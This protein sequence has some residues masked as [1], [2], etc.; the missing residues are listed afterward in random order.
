VAVSVR[1]VG[2]QDYEL[3]VS[4]NGVGIPE[5]ADGKSSKS[6]GL[7]L[8]GALVDQ[9]DGR[10]EIGRVN[11]TNVRIRFKEVRKSRGG[12]PHEETANSCSRR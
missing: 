2:K 3:I 1:A 7:D 5:D 10:I 12:A 8:V 11:G 6:F 9:L 4:D